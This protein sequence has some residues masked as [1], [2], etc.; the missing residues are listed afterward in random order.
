MRSVAAPSTSREVAA[1]ILCRVDAGGAWAGVLLRRALERA[2]FS[3]VDE[4]LAA[5][6]TLGTLRH[7]AEVD[8]A[9]SRFA[10][11]PLD[12]LPPRIRAV[13]RL[14]AYQLLFLRRI[15]PHAACNEAVE[16][17]KRAG[18]AGTARF[19]NA[20]LRRVAASPEGPPNGETAEAIALRYSHPGWLVAR[21]VER[22][23]IAE[24]R[25]LCDANNT[26]PQPV[27][28]L[29]TLRGAPD[30]IA[31]RLAERGVYTEPS[32]WLSEARRIATGRLP[33]GSSGARQAAY[34]EG[35]FSPQDEAS[36]LVARRLAPRPGDIVIDACA[37]PG[38]K[39]THLAALMENR[40]RIIACDVHSAKLGA[41]SRQCTRLGA[42]IVETHQIDAARLGERFRGVAD[43]VLVDAPCSGLGVLRRR[44]EIKWRVRPE[45]LGTR[46][47][48][49]RRILE[50]AAAALRPGGLLVYS[51][52]TFEPE[53]GANVVE[54]FLAAYSEFVPSAAEGWP[55][56]LGAEAPEPGE[57]TH[58]PRDAVVWGGQGGALLFPH[59]TGTDGFFVAALRRAT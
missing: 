51:V 37:A 31:T 9:L 52:C 4:G 27:I 25:A 14:G 22:L 55:P 21:W 48:E 34:E 41:V 46:A 59:R 16:L 56:G 2:E 11:T 3:A 13:L 12:V 33:R 23:G 44:P 42:T 58:V 7:R 39:T 36:M 49:Q 18:H 54:G 20:V 1:D 53:E 32:P 28:R 29:N 10:R 6:L 45:D 30:L 17:A 50:G 38:G 57:G 19:V 40:G 15:P 43:R 47:V 8:W 35:W 24:T 26:A 5:E